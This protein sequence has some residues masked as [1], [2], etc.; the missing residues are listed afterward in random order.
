MLG[1]GLY[2]SKTNDCM[3]SV[4]RRILKDDFKDSH[5]DGTLS[6]DKIKKSWRM[7]NM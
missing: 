4:E 7:G 3:V 5:F 6:N 1:L 2:L